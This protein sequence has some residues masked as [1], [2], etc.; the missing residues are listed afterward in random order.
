MSKYI[1]LLI[2]YYNL[3]HILFKYDI[4]NLGD[5]YDR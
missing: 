5:K 3:K 4:I 1:F 2:F